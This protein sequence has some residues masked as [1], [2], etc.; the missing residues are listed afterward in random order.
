MSADL[1]L[2]GVYERHATMLREM[3]LTFALEGSRHFTGIE[4]ARI[5]DGSADR[6]QAKAGVEA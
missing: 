3:A 2:S 4:I 5:L 1:D 6:L